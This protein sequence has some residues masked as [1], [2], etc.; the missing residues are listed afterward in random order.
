MTLRGLELFF[1]YFFSEQSKFVKS[2]ASSG[3][4][5]AAASAAISPPASESNLALERI[6]KLFSDPKFWKYA[7]DN[8]LKIRG[9]FFQLLYSLIDHVILNRS[10][11]EMKSNETVANLRKNF[12]SKLIPL[13]F[14]AIDEENST[15]SFYVWNSVLKFMKNLTALDDE[16]LWSLINVKKAL[17]PKLISLLRNHANGNANTQ[18][19]EVIYASLCPLLNNISS[20]YDDNFEEKMAFFKDM[21][22]RVCDGIAKE[23]STRS[24]RFGHA[25]NR[26][27]M[28][29]ALF[30]VASFMLDNLLKSESDATREQIFEFASTHISSNVA[31]ILFS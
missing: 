3:E 24:L 21:V 6:E 18:N 30:D 27:K 4:A 19:A 29:N 26:A 13:V 10:L 11:I 8:S 20:V 1:K 12:K 31:L 28:I 7:R 2:N 9:E 22:T 23:S 25:S 16:N 5:E 14:Y 17:V 15:C